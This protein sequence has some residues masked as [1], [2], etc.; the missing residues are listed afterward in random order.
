M[1][2]ILHDEQDPVEHVVLMI[3]ISPCIISSLFPDKN[4]F[5]V[6]SDTSPKVEK[7]EIDWEP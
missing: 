3:K 4:V 2:I 7:N 5:I 6:C 1:R